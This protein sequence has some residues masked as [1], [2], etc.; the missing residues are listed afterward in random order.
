MLGAALILSIVAG[1]GLY[2]FGKPAI[3]LLYQHGAFGKHSSKVTGTALLG[4]AVALPGMTLA[5]VLVVG[6]YAL[7]DARTPLFA[8]ILGLAA[9]WSLIV[10]LLKVFTGSHVILAIP[11]AAAGTG[12]VESLFLGALIYRR[13]RSKVLVDMGM[14]RLDRIRKQR[15]SRTIGQP[16]PFADQPVPIAVEPAQRDDILDEPTELHLNNLQ[17]EESLTRSVDKVEE[18]A[19]L[20]H[21]VGGSQSEQIDS[22]IGDAGASEDS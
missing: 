5:S 4:Y 13:L 14:L 15:A 16:L 2:L 6:Y 18:T 7:R 3:Q 8:S 21:P 22:A 1:L 11:L 19:L 10:L 9:R 12:L 17:D 20:R